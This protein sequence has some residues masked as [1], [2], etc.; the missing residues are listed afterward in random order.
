MRGTAPNSRDKVRESCSRSEFRRMAH[1][2]GRTQP[3]GDRWWDFCS[4]RMPGPWK[5][6]PAPHHPLSASS[7]QQS[8]ILRIGCANNRRDA[9]RRKLYLD[10]AAS[11]RTSFWTTMRLLVWSAERLMQQSTEAGCLPRKGN[12]MKS[13]VIK[14]S[15]NVAF[16]KTSVS[17]S[18]FWSGLKEDIVT[19]A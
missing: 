1:P 8:A 6:G 15:S 7:F 12:A 4:D 17:R 14:R 16:R 2:V 19:L 13:T 18:R 11:Y 10:L 5:T 9:A 3:E